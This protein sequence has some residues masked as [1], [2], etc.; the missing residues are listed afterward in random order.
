MGF[1]KNHYMRFPMRTLS[2]NK[3]FDDS[4]AL[5]MNKADHNDIL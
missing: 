3:N 2:G 1:Q 4:L 5:I